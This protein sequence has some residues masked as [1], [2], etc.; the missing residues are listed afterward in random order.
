MEQETE[1]FRGKEVG[2]GITG[3]WALK[4]VA[5]SMAESG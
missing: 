3:W 2:N 5:H 4:G 1:G